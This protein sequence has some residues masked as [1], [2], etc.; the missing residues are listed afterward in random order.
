ML[1]HIW[2]FKDDDLLFNTADNLVNIGLFRKCMK[3]HKIR[4]ASMESSHSSLMSMLLFPNCTKADQ[5]NVSKPQNINPY[6]KSI[7]I[8]KNKIIKFVSLTYTYPIIIKIESFITFIW[9]LWI[10]IKNCHCIKWNF[11]YIRFILLPIFKC[12]QWYFG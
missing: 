6:V 1:V 4:C 10:Y 9:I 7:N 5:L 11:F 3:L 8:D 12:K 2:T